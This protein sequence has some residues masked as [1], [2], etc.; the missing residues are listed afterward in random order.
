M[1]PVGIPKPIRPI[2]FV[3]APLLLGAALAGGLL[4]GCGGDDLVLP[5]GNSGA[6]IRVVTGDGQQ[7]TV[8]QLLPLPIVVEVTDSAENPLPGVSVQFA[9]VSAGDSADIEPA[10]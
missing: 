1:V 4:S 6:M 10:S 7:G 2:R 8:G 5:N 9:L 3:P